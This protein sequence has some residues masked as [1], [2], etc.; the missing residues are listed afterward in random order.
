[1]AP[2]TDDMLLGHDIVHHLGVLLDL[3]TDTL[4][5]KDERIPLTTSFKDGKPVIARVS[6][7]KRTVVPPNYTVRLLCQLSTPFQEYYGIEPMDEISVLMPSTGCAKGTKPVVCLVNPTDRYRTFEKGTIIGNA[8]E[9]ETLVET[10]QISGN[11]C[12]SRDMDIGIVEN[13]KDPAT[14]SLLVADRA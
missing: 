8:Q 14:A 13:F 4:I 3:Q 11:V 7:N 9:V 1:M 10:S 12:S 5:L 2:I 6:I